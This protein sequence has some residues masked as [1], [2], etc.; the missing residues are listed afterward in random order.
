MNKVFISLI[1]IIII[2]FL[3]PNSILA[4]SNN[5]IDNNYYSNT[6]IKNK[7]YNTFVNIFVVPTLKNE[8]LYQYWIHSYEEDDQ[9]KNVYRLSSF[10]FPP[11]FGREAFEIKKDGVVIFYSPGKDDRRISINGELEIKG[12]DLVNIKTK[13][14]NMKILSCENDRLI[15]QQD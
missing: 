7:L 11:S 14:L 3:I 2:F 15:I 4:I 6:N 5:I 13:N 10:K 9:T 8:C 12:P 1:S